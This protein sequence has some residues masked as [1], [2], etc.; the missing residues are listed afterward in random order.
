MR[1][2]TFVVLLA[3]LLAGY[4]LVT[5]QGLS[6]AQ[7]QQGGRY[8]IAAAA[9]DKYFACYRVDTVTGSVD[10]GYSE[11]PSGARP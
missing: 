9:N 11:N 7:D 8:Q 4:A 10:V 6:H 5:F 3:V 2:Q 1:T